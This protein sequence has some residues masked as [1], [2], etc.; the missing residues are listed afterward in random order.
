MV[1]TIYDVFNK[2]IGKRITRELVNHIKFDLKENFDY[3][4]TEQEI[5]EQIKKYYM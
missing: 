2:H 4:Y 1:L 3:D 5:L